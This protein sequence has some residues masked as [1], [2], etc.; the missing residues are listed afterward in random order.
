[1]NWFRRN[2]QKILV[3]KAIVMATLTLGSIYA[4]HLKI[5]EAEEWRIKHPCVEF[6]PGGW[7]KR[8]GIYQ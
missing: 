7:C 2:F 8:E 5:K 6:T 1:M 3:V 4:L